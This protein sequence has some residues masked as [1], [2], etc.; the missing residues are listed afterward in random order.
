MTESTH[1]AAEEA[2][3][4]SLEGR[5]IAANLHPFT[6]LARHEETG[7]LV[8]TSG[9][10]VYVT[11]DQGRDYIE[12]VAGLWSA[13]LGF[14]GEDTMIDAIM[15]QLK[16]LPFYHQFAHKSH[17]PGIELA[18][19]ILELLPRNMSKVFFN[20]SG[21]EANDTAVK[22]VWYYN[23]A[24]G[25]PKKKKI[26]SHLK[27][28]H[29]VTIA[30]ASVC[31]LPRLHADFDLPLP[32]M[33]YC[34]C[35][36]YYRYGKPNET[37][38]QFAHRLAENLEAM[39]L[40]EDPDTVA[41][42]FAEPI[43][44]AGGLIVPPAKY[45]ELIQPILDKY[46]ILLVSDEII[47]GFGRTGE[48][49]GH[50]SNGMKP[51]IVTMAK[52]L[53]ASYLPI[54]ATAISEQLYQTI[55]DNSGKLGVF[56]HGYTYSGHPVCAAAALEALKIYKERKILDHVQTVA[57]A[58]IKRGLGF[59]DHPMVGEVR[60]KGLLVALEV[61]KNKETKEPFAA[62]D[63]VGM[64]IQDAAQEEGVIVRALGDTIAVSPP[65]IITEDEIDILFDRLA[66]A[67]G[68]VAA[69]LG[70]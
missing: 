30:A 51:D 44:G 4:L 53:S 61:V 11:D 21:S 26:L 27:G 62:T 10:G 1:R 45:Y 18:E 48:M 25:R 42:F 2:T 15:N 50:S 41:A 39:I 22:L 59:A 8:V 28:Y 31:G 7:P 64:M 36:H 40:R 57:P 12:G 55:R 49:F 67:F 32:Q 60:T 29:G 56:A 14:G 16:T 17:P 9:R 65:L 5:D 3:N 70:Y 47:C 34:D 63:G 6:N 54:S 13:S 38:D 46:D 69:K 58:F 66:R 23:N 37:E 24:L 35:P 33:R 43:L 52:A 20:G 68:R 19:R